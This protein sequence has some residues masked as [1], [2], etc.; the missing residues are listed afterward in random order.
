ML[1]RVR[2]A[3]AISP[4]ASPIREACD[5]TIASTFDG[6]FFAH[7][8]ITSTPDEM[9]EEVSA[10]VRYVA[11]YVAQNGPF[12]AILG[13]SQVTTGWVHS[14][15]SR[16]ALTLACVSGGGAA[17]GRGAGWTA[18]CVAEPS[19]PSSSSGKTRPATTI[20]A[21]VDTWLNDF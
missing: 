18:R 13:F 7:W 9:N 21:A 11:E 14:P 5:A 6:P 3:H 1:A 12:H 19:F 20:V 17:T 10:T 16:A 2:T 15:I 4:S 8:N